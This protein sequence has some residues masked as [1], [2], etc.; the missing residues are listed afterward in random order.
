MIYFI[1]QGDEYIK[2]GHGGDPESRLSQLQVGNPD[3]LR[4]MACFS[5]GQ[6]EE[7][8]LHDFLKTLRIR[9]EWF[10]FNEEVRRF[11]HVLVDSD[12]LVAAFK[13]W[14]KEFEEA[15]VIPFPVTSA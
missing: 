6:Q 15:D 7:Q 4:L 12:G 2:I 5:G 11:I 1:T 13:N 10:E 3:E 14:R 9:G 8:H